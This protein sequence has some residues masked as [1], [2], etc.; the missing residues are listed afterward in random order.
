[1]V[2]IKSQAYKKTP[3]A[4]KEIYIQGLKYYFGPPFSI[5]V[6]FSTYIFKIN[7]LTREFLNI[8]ILNP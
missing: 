3:I 5:L 8:N 7:I 2:L 1:M 6:H 4:S